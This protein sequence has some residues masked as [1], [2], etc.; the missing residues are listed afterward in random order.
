M[1]RIASTFRRRLLAPRRVP[2]VPRLVP[3]NTMT[4]TFTHQYS[5]AAGNALE[6]SPSHFENGPDELLEI[7]SRGP[8]PDASSDSG[9]ASGQLSALSTLDGEVEIK[10]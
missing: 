8:D 9:P 2:P 4:H 10:A 3:V 5:R 7:I 1:H 6:N